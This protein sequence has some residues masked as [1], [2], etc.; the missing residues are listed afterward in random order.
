MVPVPDEAAY[1]SE[2]GAG[3]RS[4]RT[5]PRADRGACCVSS[6][7]RA[8]EKLETVPATTAAGIKAKFDL[9][10]TRL[11]TVFDGSCC[12]GWEILSDLLKGIDDGLSHLQQH[13][14]QLAATK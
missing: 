3:L 13:S 1:R 7:T 10:H 11:E 5:A 4:V 2:G 9:L 6:Y 12:S 14:A 8:V